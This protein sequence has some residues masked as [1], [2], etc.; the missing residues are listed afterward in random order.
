MTSPV[1]RDPFEG[2]FGGTA[3]A[4][5]FS[6]TWAWLMAGFTLVALGVAIIGRLLPPVLVFDLVALW[7]LPAFAVLVAIVV[8]LARANGVTRVLA[9]LLL[10]TWLILGVGWWWVGS[11]P[12]PSRAADVTGPPQVP[13]EVAL[14]I[15]LD[16]EVSITVGDEYVYSVRMGDRGGMTGAPD[17]LEARQDE[18]MAITMQERVD[19][20]WYRSSGWDVTL[21][22]AALWQI[23][24][25]ATVVDLQLSGVPLQHLG[26]MG[27]GRIV[28][29]DPTGLVIIDLQGVLE[30][31]IPAGVPVQVI[32]SAEVPDG[33]TT[34][35]TGS[36]SPTPGEGFLIT[37]GGGQGIRVIER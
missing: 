13:S 29:G 27:D 21:H 36:T 5:E 3:E 15:A 34:S 2:G 24:V 31:S 16:G 32:G 30:V 25:K 4:S 37:T 18:V 35:G 7:P 14:A 6:S 8:R 1:G 17:V 10:V 19:S 9:P 11:P 23:H 20:G 28:L 26:V 33:W 22:P 12:S